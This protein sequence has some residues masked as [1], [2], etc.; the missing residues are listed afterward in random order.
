MDLLFLP[1]VLLLIVHFLSAAAPQMVSLL[2]KML[3][4]RQSNETMRCCPQRSM[5]HE[6]APLSTA[7][8][9]TDLEGSFIVPTGRYLVGLEYCFT[10]YNIIHAAIFPVRELTDLAT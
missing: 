7:C 9:G 8:H 5:V 1:A 3:T 2:N 6:P 4:Y 10:S